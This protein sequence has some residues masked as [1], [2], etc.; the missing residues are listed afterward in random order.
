MSAS[1][2]AGLT[3]YG[4]NLLSVVYWL[5]SDVCCLLA[6]VTWLRSAVYCLVVSA[7]YCLLSAVSSCK[8][9][10]WH[11]KVQI[12]PSHTK[13]NT[14]IPSLCH[15][16]S[17]LHSFTLSLTHTHTHTDT[18]AHAN[19]HTHTHTQTRTHTHTHTYTHTHRLAADP[20]A[21][22]QLVP[23]REGHPFHTGVCVCVCVCV[24][25]YLLE[26]ASL[27]HRCV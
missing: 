10:P 6:S 9:L 12:L 14:L 24:N 21:S 23:P 16:H 19:T 7:A 2:I 15:T 1:R 13:A 26:R 5:L 11:F 3:L 17:L 18:H 20:V 27:S 8:R 25:W 4:P 22:G